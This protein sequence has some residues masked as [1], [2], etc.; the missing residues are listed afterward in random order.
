MKNKQTRPRL[1]LSTVYVSYWMA[2]NYVQLFTYYAVVNYDCQSFR[3]GSCI[4][5]LSSALSFVFLLCQKLALPEPLPVLCRL[6]SEGYYLRS[7]GAV[8]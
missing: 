8:H 2:P 6:P 7:S 1:V 3:K 5:L 4:C